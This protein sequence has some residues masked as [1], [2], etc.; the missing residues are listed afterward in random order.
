LHSVSFFCD[1]PDARSVAVV[2]D[3]NQWDP[4]ANPMTRMPDGQWVARL[5][6]RHGH[7][8]YLFLVDGQARL[9]PR[10]HGTVRDA[11]EW[12]DAASLLEVS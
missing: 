12:L 4:G 5:E 3:F 10:A 6:L 2:G 8:R 9:D 1:A 11:N 7:Y